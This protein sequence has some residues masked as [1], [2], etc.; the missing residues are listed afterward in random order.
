M[1]QQYDVKDNWGRKVGTATASGGDGCFGELSAI[2]LGIVFVIIAIGTLVG[3]IQ[4]Q[5][6]PPPPPPWTVSLRADVTMRSGPYHKSV[7]TGNNNGI[8]L[9]NGDS[10][11]FTGIKPPHA[12]MYTLSIAGGT[13]RDGGGDYSLSIIVNGKVQRVYKTSGEVQ[14][15]TPTTVE[16]QQGTNTINL[17]VTGTDSI[18]SYSGEYLALNFW[19][20]DLTEIQDATPTP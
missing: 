11:T 10:L 15:F 18:D 1:G 6:N 17:T 12:G 8:A 14:S 7:T 3:N 9:E 4:K 13:L 19:G 16:L 20:L 5:L 2:V